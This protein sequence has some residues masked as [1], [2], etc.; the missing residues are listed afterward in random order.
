MEDNFSE[1]WEA[2][3]STPSALK[4]LQRKLNL[5]RC[6]R[7]LYLGYSATIA[8]QFAGYLVTQ[9][10][11]IDQLVAFCPIPGDFRVGSAAWLRATSQ[12][13]NVAI[14]VMQNPGHS[15]KSPDVIWLDRLIAQSHEVPSW[16]Y[17]L[18]CAPVTYPWDGSYLYPRPFCPKL[19]E[20]LAQQPE[21]AVWMQSRLA[22]A[23]PESDAAWH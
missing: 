22:K 5:S 19:F 20:S 18:A 15:R 11:G 1:L 10:S 21:A 8:S 4:A 14:R 7:D 6:D 9:K 23:G 2:V 16:I 3:I 17:S 13:L 12:Q